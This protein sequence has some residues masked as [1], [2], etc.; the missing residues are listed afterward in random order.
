MGKD[1]EHGFHL[2]PLDPP[3][4]A[5]QCLVPDVTGSKGWQNTKDKETQQLL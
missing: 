5:S 3:S 1:K 2:F 4:W